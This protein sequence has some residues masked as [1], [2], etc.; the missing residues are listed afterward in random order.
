VE[1][2]E[3]TALVSNASGRAKKIEAI[4]ILRAVAALGVTLTHAGLAL[5]HYGDLNVTWT[6]RGISGVDLFFLISGFIVVFISFADPKAKPAPSRFLLRRLIRIVPLYWLVTTVYLVFDAYPVERVAGSYL[7]LPLGHPPVVPPGWTLEYEMFFYVMFAACLFFTRRVAVPLLVLSLFAVTLTG[8]AVYSDRIVLEFALGT[9]VGLAYLEGFRA[10]WSVRCAAIACG[11]ALLIAADPGYH[12]F[13]SFGLPCGLILAGA[14]LGPPPKFATSI[15]P[16]ILLG[17]A[18]YALYL[19]HMPIVRV[20]AR[21]MRDSGI[22]LEIFQITY[23]VAAVGAAVG[24]ATLVHL[25]IEK[26]MTRFLCRLLAS[27]HTVS[28]RERASTRM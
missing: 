27:P 21:A 9:L 18:S 12:R 4:Q 28:G 2:K 16:L 13:I 1:P 24:V 22:N 7:F 8:A 23:F 20:V 5:N 11:I 6:V 15:G 19:T 25:F 26:P 14:V 3:P 10:S 17:D